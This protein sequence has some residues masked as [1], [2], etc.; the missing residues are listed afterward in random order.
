M[1]K[2]TTQKSVNKNGRLSDNHQRLFYA[3]LAILIVSAVLL[4]L[5]LAAERRTQQQKQPAPQVLFVPAQAVTMG[6]AVM[7]IGNPVYSSGSPGFSAP[8]GSRYLIVN[9]TVKNTSSRPINILPA[10]DTYIKDTK[11]H[12]GYLT[13]YALKNPFRAG[14]LPPGEQIN[15][16]LSYLVPSSAPVKFFIDAPWSGGAVTFVLK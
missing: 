14:E 16:E 8:S 5:A 13:P 11:G 9:L 1:S 12:V 7:T 10:N 6:Q 4:G 2:K 15:G 3:S